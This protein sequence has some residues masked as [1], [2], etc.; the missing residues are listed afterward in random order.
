[1]KRYQFNLATVLWARQ[2]QEDVA[3]ARLMMAHQAAQQAAEALAESRAH[4]GSA[5]AINDERF[6]AGRQLWELAG[7]EVTDARQAEEGARSA[8]AEAMSKYLEAARAVSVI[9]HLDERRRDEHAL[10]AQREEANTTDEIVT[11]RFGRSSGVA[12]PG[13]RGAR[14]PGAK[15]APPNGP[16]EP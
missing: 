7:L 11:S 13:R 8:V 10:A 4:Y 6:M 3:R 2:A 9:E 16:T 1:M 12:H 15:P 5:A 14:A